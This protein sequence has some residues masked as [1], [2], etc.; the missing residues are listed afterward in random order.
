MLSYSSSPANRSKS[1]ARVDPAITEELRLAG[2][3][4]N[5][6]QSVRISCPFCRATHEQ[7]MRLTRRPAALLFTCYRASC[8]VRGAIQSN[9]GIQMHDSK[10]PPIASN[11]F[12]L[13][14]VSPPEDLVEVVTT[15][16]GISREV[17]HYSGMRWAPNERSMCFPVFDVYGKRTGTSTK[18]LGDKV[19]GRRKSTLYYEDEPPQYYAPP[20]FLR[21]GSKLVWLVEDVL[22]CL[23]I[24]THG[25]NSIALLGTNVNPGLFS[26]LSSNFQT[27]IIALDPDALVKA[28]KIQQELSSLPLTV[29]VMSF[30]KDPKDVEEEILTTLLAAYGERL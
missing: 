2:M 20:L 15:R 19:A 4:L 29:K 18:V 11:P 22:S 9:G 14:T 25:E 27:V 23:R 21:S 6:S 8:G 3:H 17:L 24:T 30:N 16:Y 5:D 28:L 12:K 10:P 13:D 26:A 7:S 1:S